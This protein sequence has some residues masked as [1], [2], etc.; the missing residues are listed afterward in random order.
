MNEQ[1]GEC[2]GNITEN[3]H[4]DVLYSSLFIN[5]LQRMVTIYSFFGE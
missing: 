2:Q 3:T 1:P 4:F 5:K